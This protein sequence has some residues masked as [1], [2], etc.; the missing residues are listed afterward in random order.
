M[1]LVHVIFFVG[2]DIG[3]LVTER[4]VATVYCSGDSIVEFVTS[5]P[6]YMNKTTV[7]LVSGTTNQ[8][9]ITLSWVPVTDQAG[10]QVC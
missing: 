8:Y 3:A 10:P 1:F 2:V 4:I 7:A 6:L 9:Y 5:S